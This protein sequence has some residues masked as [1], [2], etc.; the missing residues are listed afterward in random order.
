VP[1]PSPVPTL[2]VCSPLADT[3]VAE[4]PGMVSN[5]FLPPA[6]GSDNP[7]HGVDLAI[8]DPVH[9]IAL[10]G[11]PVQAVLP[12]EVA[13]LV[14]DRF[15]YGYAV[16]IETPLDAATPEWWAQAGIP[17][18]APTLA[19]RSALSCPNFSLPPYM[20]STLRSVYVLYA[21]LQSIEE[22][23]VGQPVTC[24]QALGSVGMSGNALNPHL[25]VEVR[26]A[27]AGIRFSSMAHYDSSASQDEMAAYCLWRVSG[28][29]Q[30]VDPLNF[31]VR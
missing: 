9:R 2:A 7:H 3:L 19:P 22:L 12:G 26:A 29:F 4:L 21:H 10:S 24:G 15:P 13:M 14:K 31:I 25:H 8:L 18:P 5:P 20:D 28:L 16:L 30:L 1:T 23:N 6:P 11:S 27:P 17:T